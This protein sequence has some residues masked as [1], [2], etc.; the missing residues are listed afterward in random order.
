M[1]M[2]DETITDNGQQLVQ[3]VFDLL[4]SKRNTVQM[5]ARIMS[6]AERYSKAEMLSALVHLAGRSG[7][8]Q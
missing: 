4:D 3:D 5:T 7:V 8:H 6:L 2:R 1:S